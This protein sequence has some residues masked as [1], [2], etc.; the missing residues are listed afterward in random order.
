VARTHNVTL[1]LDEQILRGAKALAAERGVSVSAL[2][3]QQLERLLTER[4]CY[5]RARGAALQRLARGQ[6]LG[7]VRLPRRDELHDR[8][9]HR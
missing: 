1:T 2:L 6:A 9:K 5:A 8:A 7:G 4:R 3:G